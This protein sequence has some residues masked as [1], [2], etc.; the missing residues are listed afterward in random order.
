MDYKF[1][2]IVKNKIENIHRVVR[3]TLHTGDGRRVLTSMAWRHS[4]MNMGSRQTACKDGPGRTE[5][6]SWQGKGRKKSKPQ[7]TL[8]HVP[9]YL[10]RFILRAR[11]LEVPNWESRQT[12]KWWALSDR[13]VLLK[14][15]LNN[16]GSWEVREAKRLNLATTPGFISNTYIFWKCEPIVIHPRILISDGLG[17]HISIYS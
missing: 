3:V 13:A 11:D 6:P 17:I 16:T 2:T 4:K 7:P 10:E 8:W 5:V 1:H 15:S 14:E 9:L 12:S